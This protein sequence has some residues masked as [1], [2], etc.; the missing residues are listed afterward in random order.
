[1]QDRIIHL[2]EVAQR[3]GASDLHLSVGKAPIFRIN[4]E[5]KSDDVATLTPE[6]TDEMAQALMSEDSYHEL[7]NKREID[8][9]YELSGSERFRIN[10]YYQRGTISL[11]VRAIPA[12]VPNLEE[13]QLPGVLKKIVDEPQG[14]FLVT[15]P[16]GSGKST[17]LAAM[18]DFMNHTARKHIIT[19]EDPIEYV[20][21]HQR[22]TIDQRE[23]GLDTLSFANGLRSSLRQDPDVILVGE[24]RDL[25]TI[26]TAITAAETGHLVL[27][28]L[29]TLGAAAT[30]DRI[31]DVF[32]ANQQRQIR[33]QLAHVLIG[34]LS[35]QLLPTIDR[36]KRIVATELLI[37]NVAVANLIR[38]EKVYQIVN[39]IQTSKDADMH[40]LE[41][42]LKKLVHANLV[43]SRIAENYIQEMS[44]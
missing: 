28:T 3:V 6:D 20:H 33:I 4:G 38:G 41:M 13:L 31:I 24:L 8:F 42:S 23:V 17:T 7:K 21:V 34:V 1:M 15:G 32:P 39:L 40:T 30:I 36:R 29:H 26:S 10:A 27:G 5:L 35:Q 16:T 44:S 37:N 12:S 2:L 19:L 14:L 18:I 25:E 43:S 22:C 11:A 9:S